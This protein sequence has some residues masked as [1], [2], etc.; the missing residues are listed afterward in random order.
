MIKIKYTHDDRA[1]ELISQKAVLDRKLLREITDYIRFTIL[2]LTAE[3]RGYDG[4]AFRPYSTQYAI[5]RKKHGRPISKVDLN[6]TGK[7]LASFAT[8]ILRENFARL[9][10][11]SAREAKKMLGNIDRGRNPIGI[12][13]EMKSEIFKIVEDHIKKMLDQG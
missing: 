7:M 6:F 13:R 2:K 4:K 9:G 8:T 12:S 11:K 1:L 3:G 5:F 10:F